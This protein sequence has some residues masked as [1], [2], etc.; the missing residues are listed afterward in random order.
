M[1]VVT[2]W[3]MTLFLVTL[4]VVNLT[5]ENVLGIMA[6]LSAIPVMLYAISLSM[7]ED[8]KLCSN[9]RVGMDKRLDGYDKVWWCRVCHNEE[10]RD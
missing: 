9:C 5:L 2:Y 10:N 7:K 4:G 8:T 1:K 6:L 3:L